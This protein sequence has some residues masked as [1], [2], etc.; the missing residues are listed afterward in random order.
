MKRNWL[1]GLGVLLLLLVVAW[2]AFGA[3]VITNA[4]TITYDFGDG[5]PIAVIANPARVIVLARIPTPSAS[6][7]IV[8]PGSE[9]TLTQVIEGTGA[10]ATYKQPLT[11]ATYVAGSTKLDGVTKPDPTIASGIAAFGPYTIAE[12]SEATLTFKLKAQ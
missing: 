10:G 11:G 3:T 9:F 4:A 6:P 1:I 5:N 12:G 8:L 7:R 2:F